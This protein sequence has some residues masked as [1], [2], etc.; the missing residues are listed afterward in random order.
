MYQAADFAAF[1]ISS[2]VYVLSVVKNPVS[3]EQRN[4]ILLA[5]ARIWELGGGVS[6]SPE[7]TNPIFNLRGLIRI[8]KAS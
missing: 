7:Q 5:R 2:V 6:E 4:P 1:L 8:G 3:S